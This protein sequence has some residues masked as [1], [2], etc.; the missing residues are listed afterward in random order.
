MRG[1]IHYAKEQSYPNSGKIKSKSLC[2][3]NSDNHDKN[4]ISMTIIENRVNCKTCL[5]VIKSK[6]A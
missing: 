5:K 2:G 1:K 4:F 6:T 3:I